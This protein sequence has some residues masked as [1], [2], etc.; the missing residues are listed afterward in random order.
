MPR[1]GRLHEYMEKNHPKYSRNL[2][3]YKLINN[4]FVRK[5]SQNFLLLLEFWKNVAKGRVTKESK[6]RSIW[7]PWPRKKFCN[8][9]S[10]A[11]VVG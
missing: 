6:I 1:T 7:S 4:I 5:S 9:K 8:E 10:S 3:L 11:E 2:F